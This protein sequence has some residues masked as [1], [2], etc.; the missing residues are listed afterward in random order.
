[1]LRENRRERERE[2]VRNREIA[3]LEFMLPRSLDVGPRFLHGT[4]LHF[5]F[6]VGEVTRDRHG[7]GCEQRPSPSRLV[8]HA[9]MAVG[10]AKQV[11]V[12]AAN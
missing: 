7:W 9:F 11:V 12:T 3:R 1:M 6:T 2:R 4:S 10:V 5:Q 8:D